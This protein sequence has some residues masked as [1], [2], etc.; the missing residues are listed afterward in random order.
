MKTTK[1]KYS[2]AEWCRD[3]NR[4]DYLDRWDYELNNIGP[5]DV[6]FRSGKKYWFKCDRQLHESEQHPLCN[7]VIWKSCKLCTKCLSFGQWVLDTFGAEAIDLYYSHQNT[8]DWFSIGIRSSKPIWVKCEE[9]SHPDYRTTPNKFFEGDRCPVCSNHQ[10]VAGINDVATT[11]PEYIQYFRNPDDANLYSVHSGKYVWFKCPLC[12]NEKYI[13]VCTAFNNGYS[14]S[15]CGDGVS[16]NNKFIYCFLKQL[17]NRD[18]FVLQTEKVFEWSKQLG[19]SRSKK[20]YDFYIH[21]GQDLIIEAHGGQHFDYGFDRSCGG[22]TVEEEQKN[23]TIK[24]TLAIHNGILPTNYIVLDCRKSTKDFLINSIMNSCL[25]DIL[26]FT[27]NEINWDQC[28]NFACSNLVKIVSDLWDFGVRGLGEFFSMTGLATSTVSKYLRQADSLGWI[29]YESPANK[30]VIC[31]DNNCVFKTS[32]ICSDL[33]NEIFGVYIKP[34]HIQS[35]ANGEIS[36][37]HGFHFQYLTRNEFRI[38]QADEPHRVY[39]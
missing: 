13:D 17:Q 14:C 6:H 21:N 23:D 2:F 1:V 20:L 15:S 11:H 18:G 9:Q 31:T 36:S 5:E 27:L 29:V 25:P 39:E 35:N 30:P 28:E 10:I 16:F 38:I 32:R 3:N 8:N 34:K 12:G 7:V 26:K 24:Y 33:S 4:Q 22:R 37:T 19:N